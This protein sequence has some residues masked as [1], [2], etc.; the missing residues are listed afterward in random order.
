MTAEGAARTTQDKLNVFVSSRLTEC[1][2]ERA[3][4]R[5]AILSLKQ[6]PVLFEH[7]GARTYGARDLYLS[8][9]RDSQFVVA[10]YKA[11]Y[12]Y[13]DVANGM[14]ISGLEDE[15]RAAFR[16]RIG[17]LAYI[18]S[19]ETARDQRLS[20]LLS[21]LQE[22]VTSATYEEPA[23]LEERIKADLASAMSEM[24]LSAAK[25]ARAIDVDANSLLGRMITWSGPLQDRNDLL[26]MISDNSSGLTCI[27]GESG[28]GKTTLAAQYARFSKACFVRVT[29]LATKDV[30]SACANAI[31][32]QRDDIVVHGSL[33]SAHRDFLEGWQKAESITLVVDECA[34]PEVLIVAV[35]AAGGTS[36]KKRLIITSP[37]KINGA[38]NVEVP[39]L[40]ENEEILEAA[41]TRAAQAGMLH[42]VHTDKTFSS[43]TS[44][45]LSY[46]AI[47]PQ[48]ITAAELSELRGGSELNDAELFFQEARQIVDESPRGFKL[49]HDRI[50]QRLLAQLREAP[51]RLAFYA[52]R[53]AKFFENKGDIRSAYSTAIKADNGIEQEFAL[54]ALKQAARD[55]DWRQAVKIANTL[56]LQAQADERIEEAFALSLQLVVPLEFAGDVGAAN[57]V[58]EAAR[59]LCEN[60]DDDAREDLHEVEV[61]LRARRE[62]S[63]ES[64]A[65]LIYVHDSYKSRGLQWDQARIALELSAVFIA[66]K[67]SSR[68][69][70]YAR[71]SLAIFEEI[72]D[73]TGVNYAKRNL[74]SAL[75]G[76]DEA[77]PEAETLLAE[78]VGNQSDADNRRQRAWECNLRVRQLRKSGR[79]SEAEALAREAISIG[80]ELGDEYLKAINSINL[81][82]VYS[83]LNNTDSALEAYRDAGLAAQKCGRRDIEAD[84]S[85]LSAEVINDQFETFGFQKLE[86]ADRARTYAEHAL[87][88]LSE[89]ANSY[90]KSYA[91]IELG[92]ALEH[93]G[94]EFAAGAAFFQSAAEARRGGREELFG[95][96]LDFGMSYT[97]DRLESYIEGLCVALDVTI[98]NFDRD[99]EK[100]LFLFR[101][102]AVA[103]PRQE[104]IHLMGLHLMVLFDYVPAPFH[105]GLAIL[106]A[107]TMVEMAKKQQLPPWRLLQSVIPVAAALSKSGSRF[108]FSELA[109]A[110]CA[111]DSSVFY[112]NDE[113]GAQLWTLSMNWGRPVTISI[114]PMDDSLATQV[115]CLALAGFFKAF[116]GAIASELPIQDPAASEVAISVFSFDRAPSDLQEMLKAQGVLEM[117]EGGGCSVT[118]PVD[119]E[120]MTPTIITIA[121]DFLEHINLG[122]P[123]AGAFQKLFA[124]TAI[125]LIYQL[126]KGQVDLD[127]IRPKVI[128]IVRK[129]V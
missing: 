117:L 28:A 10:I 11:G 47:S 99:S 29:G 51:Q 116:E 18:H 127:A 83:D 7:L 89:S 109:Q 4:A 2:A 31:P 13:I 129:T 33:L 118:R 49:I 42:L 91:Y 80:D 60:L 90:G 107:R 34:D 1:A 73:E 56:L 39:P 54:A 16:L 104:L 87:G 21:K 120:D 86:S 37:T 71:S 110:I 43:V 65:E 22:H 126:L 32:T 57:A 62:L 96:S 23:E 79:Y 26:T 123:P 40:K 35:G 12:G 98:A 15:V 59:R 113:D 50:S 105:G 101:Q 94:D 69:A 38:M 106:T 108:V 124:P 36:T 111:S 74:I 64:I 125:E 46:L 5:N 72:G 61:S 27:Y 77:N 3:A 119:F 45:F 122:V 93:A 97:F 63:K 24:V 85:R 103:V 114:A 17:L 95:R 53:L 112:R 81:G 44:E 30:F 82:N 84:S 76:L 78:I 128:S 41:S 55:G 102:L 100:L 6:N 68:A 25:R 92:R 19:D 58:L 52:G 20:S 121:P 14:E 9:L 70:E 88:L 8:R 75:I 67:E 66:A 115:A 48:P